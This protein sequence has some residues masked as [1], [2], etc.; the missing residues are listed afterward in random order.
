MKTISLV[1]DFRA[2]AERAAATQARRTSAGPAAAGRRTADGTVK[3]TASTQLVIETVSVKDKNGNPVE[4]LTAKDF[5]ITED[6]VPQTIS[7]LRIPE[8]AKRLR[9]RTRPASRGQAGHHDSRRPR[10]LP[11][12]ASPR[13]RSRPKSPAT[14]AIATAA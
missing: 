9:R 13:T 4:G 1:L 11:S 6:G 8:A 7:F 14:Y 12:P 2:P 5:T 3:F 10:R